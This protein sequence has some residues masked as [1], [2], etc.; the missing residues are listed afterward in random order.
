MKYSLVLTLIN[1]PTIISHNKFNE[2]ALAQKKT[3]IP[4]Y[5]IFIEFWKNRNISISEWQKIK[6]EIL[7]GHKSKN[8]SQNQ[9]IKKCFCINFDKCMSFN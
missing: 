4:F 1:D 2:S 5:S 9:T 6:N 8:V 3:G 7:N